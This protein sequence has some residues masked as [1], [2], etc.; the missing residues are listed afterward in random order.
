SKC[1]LIL[2]RG[3]TY[4]YFYPYWD[5]RHEA[6]RAGQLPLWNSDIFMGIP[7]LANPQIGIYYPLNWILIHFDA[8]Q[9]IRISIIL[10]IVLAGLG[11]TLFFRT[12][13]NK[14]P[15]ASTL[16]GMI[17]ALGGYLG[18]HVEQINQLQG[19]AWLPWLLLCLHLIMTH[20]QYGRYILLLG[21][22]WAL[23][24]LSGHTQTVFISGIA[25]G[26]YVL[27]ALPDEVTIRR[28]LGD[29]IK[30]SL[31]VVVALILAI[32]QLIPTLE[33]I[34]M[35]NRGSGLTANEATAFSLPPTYLARALLPSYDGLLF[36][37]YI[38]YIG[39][40][41]LGLGLLAIVSIRRNRQDIVWF[42]FALIGV[43]FAMGRFT[44]IY[45]AIAD[46]PGFN[47]F[48]VPARWLALSAFG[49]AILAGRGLI[50]LTENHPKALSK[51]GVISVLLIMMALGRVLPILQVDIVGS[52]QPTLLTLSLWG[53]SLI[54]L[55]VIFFISRKK[56]VQSLILIAVS[57]ELFLASQIMP[58]NDLVPQDVY[59]GQRFTIS[60]MLAL[61]DDEASPRMLSISN[62]LF[63]LGDV[64]AIQAR[65]QQ[66]GL[67]N[68]AQ[69]I[70]LTANKS[71]EIISPNL[72]MT[73]SIPTIDG[74]GGGVLPTIYY[75][76][77]TSLLLPE[78]SLRT[79]DGR[80]G[81]MMALPD[82]RG[83][84]IPDLDMLRLTNTDY[85]IVDKNFDVPHEGIFFDTSLYAFW[86]TMPAHPDFVFDEVQILFNIPLDAIDNEAFEFLGSE[87]YLVTTDWDTFEALLET[88]AEH[89]LGASVVNSRTDT[90]LQLT[91]NGFERILSSDIK[92]YQLES[93][94]RV[95]LATTITSTAD[96][97][98]GHEQALD[99]LRESP[100]I[101]VVHDAP[102]LE[103]ATGTA[104]IVQYSDTYIEIA[105]NSSNETYLYLADAYYSGWQAT[106]NNNPETIYRAN[107]MFRAVRVPA[108]ESIV[109]FEF[110]PRLW[111]Q[112]GFFGIGAWIISVML[113]GGLFLRNRE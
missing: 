20:H 36:T 90:F 107:V 10:H 92:I 44:P 82:C 106:V 99:I 12:A 54:V 18:A 57:V 72:N 78:D 71:Q 56:I 40:I 105:V 46:L 81:E 35:S 100:Q 48:R 49:M 63:D 11:T 37:E 2:A 22:V 51:I 52:S 53:T 89:I 21:I 15:I 73:W 65:Y 55:S 3:D 93:S 8:P 16:A 14:S 6:F 112:S 59:L 75:S 43:L 79:T 29:L 87:Y 19:L 62:R 88:Q 86:S 83:A 27:F 61:S 68:N 84:C 74:Y 70:A 97:W 110:A 109:V 101:L 1:E 17:F 7:L 9:A 24:I 50:V 67:D 23:Q 58:F 77:F 94:P 103:G 96:N 64:S 111:Y 33:L 80:L 31:G 85:L 95:T 32:P 60:Q 30:L 26:L 4:H 47:L 98:Y 66:L 76:Q 28:K 113:L 45:L 104:D 39:V 91:P 69:Q 38:A 13:I 102:I 25:L 34:G 41:A 42:V 5:I 108:G